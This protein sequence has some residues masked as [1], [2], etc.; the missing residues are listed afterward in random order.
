MMLTVTEELWMIAVS[1]KPS[2]MPRTGL[3]RDANIPMIKGDSFSPAMALDMVESPMNSTPKP[4]ITSPNF[5][6]FCFLQNI[7]KST[8]ASKITGA[9]FSSLKDTKSAVTVVP[10]LEP[11]MT[12]AA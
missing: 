10:I 6:T 1:T 4:T 2:K 7:T 5:D 11:K 3:C 9:N 8:P 12:P